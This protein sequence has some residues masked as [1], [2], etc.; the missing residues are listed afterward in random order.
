MRRKS[1]PRSRSKVFLSPNARAWR[2]RKKKFVDSSSDPVLAERDAEMAGAALGRAFED[3]LARYIAAAGVELEQMPSGSAL[4]ALVAWRQ[5]L[6][7]VKRRFEAAIR[8]WSS[9]DLQDEPTGAADAL[10]RVE[11]LAPLYRLGERTPR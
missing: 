7:G 5:E 4:R 6:T 8:E 11:E 2:S 1:P 10:R 3:F 9:D